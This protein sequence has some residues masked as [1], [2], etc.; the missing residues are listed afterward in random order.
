M[1]ITQGYLIH[2]NSHVAIDI[3]SCEN[4]PVVWV[5]PQDLK[6]TEGWFLQF[7]STT[8][9]LQQIS[10]NSTWVVD[11]VPGRICAFYIG[12]MTAEL[13]WLAMD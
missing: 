8:V 9:I 6:Q 2:C 4:W 12:N 1:P 10:H 3:D 7:N 11:N 13:F 5:C